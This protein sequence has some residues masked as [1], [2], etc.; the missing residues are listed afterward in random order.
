ML[1]PE[2]MVLIKTRTKQ[3]VYQKDI[4]AELGVHPKT[5]SRA[6]KRLAKPAPPRPPRPSKLAPFTALVDRWLADGVWNAVVI[7][8]EL[9]AAGYTG[10]LT[11][12]RSYIAPRRMQRP[13]RATVRFETVP[14][15]QLQS[16]WGTISTTIAGLSFSHCTTSRHTRSCGG[17]PA[18]P[19]SAS[20]A[21]AGG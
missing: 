7:F 2:D 4:A 20:S 18:E 16:D 9:Q 8:R 12:L 13:S 5:V 6:L 14:G 19:E 17:A 1:S 15:H 21:T 10:G 11:T 3:G